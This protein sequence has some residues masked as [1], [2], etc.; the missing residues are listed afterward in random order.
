MICA[1]HEAPEFASHIV[2]VALGMDSLGDD[3]LTFSS[4]LLASAAS[5]ARTIHLAECGSRLTNARASKHHDGLTN[6]VLFKQQLGLEIVDLKAHATQAVL[7]KKLSVAIGAT[8]ARA[9][10]DGLHTPQGLGIF[11]SCLWLLPSSRS[12]L[13]RPMQD[14]TR[15]VLYRLRVCGLR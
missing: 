15:P 10:Q 2:V 3:E 5:A 4:L 13:N 14:R 9:I 6:F 11:L 12:S 7:R 1:A 8:V